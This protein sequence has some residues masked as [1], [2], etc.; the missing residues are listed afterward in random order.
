MVDLHLTKLAT[1][2]KQEKG[3]P[4][5]DLH[6]TQD[7]IRASDT[8]RL[9]DGRADHETDTFGTPATYRPRP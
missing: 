5:T 7:R 2:M 6:S 8:S 1:G 3:Q 9:W 4:G